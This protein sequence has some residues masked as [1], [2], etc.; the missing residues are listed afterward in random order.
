MMLR[1]NLLPESYRKRRRQRQTLAAIVGVGLLIVVLLLGWWVVLS[2][3]VND[4]RDQLAAARTHNAQ[5]QAEIGRLQQFA[6]L[7]TEVQ[8]KQ[9]ALQTVM[10]G[11]VDWP[12]IMTELAMVVPGEVWLVGFTASAGQT[13]G[14]TPVGTE[15][16]PI[17]VA[18]QEPFGRIEFTGDALAMPGVAKWLI[19]LQR[20]KEFQG[21]W[22]ES[23]AST[24]LGGTTVYNFTNTIELSD[25]AASGRFMNGATP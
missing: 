20:V 12:A 13:E 1:V 5:L 3:Q 25:K 16:N 11:D 19:E 21:A 22:L 14:S 7:Q 24:Q 8:S 4:Q 9:Q 6:D 17:R 18:K 23:A 15:T 10:A 2:N